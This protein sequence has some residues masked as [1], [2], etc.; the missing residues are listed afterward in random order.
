MI[1]SR[2]LSEELRFTS[3]GNGIVN[4]VGGLY[5][6]DFY[7][8]WTF[9]GTTPNY[10]AYMDLG[11][12]ARATTARWFDAYSP[13][14]LSQY[15]TFGDVTYSLT[16][17]LKVDVGARLNRYTYRFS[18]CISGWG[19]ARGAATPSCSGDIALSA[20]SFNPKLNLSYAFS[21]DLMA[22]ATVANGFRPG[23]G[24]AVYPTTGHHLGN[25]VRRDELYKRQVAFHLRT[26]RRVELRAR[27]KGK[28]S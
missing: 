6:S 19:S 1:S 26:R 10:P 21:P 23:G 12:L 24:N 17:E 25:S 27:R 4:W 13:T 5:Y 3:R 20:N 18:S 15:A 2:Q 11:T 8:L 9:N 22:Y 14:T 16:E 28:T 7:S